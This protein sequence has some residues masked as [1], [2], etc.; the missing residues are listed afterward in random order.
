LAGNS[1]NASTSYH[2]TIQRCNSGIVQAHER[3]VIHKQHIKFGKSTGHK[4][5]DQTGGTKKYK[6]D[7]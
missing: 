6:P 5:N 7:F 2:G 1:L 3:G 4:S